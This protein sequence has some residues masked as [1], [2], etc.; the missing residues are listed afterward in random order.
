MKKFLPL[1]L[2]LLI[3]TYK[4]TASTLQNFITKNFEIMNKKPLILLLGATVGVSVL[5]AHFTNENF[6]NQ[7]LAKLIKVNNNDN[8]EIHIKIPKTPRMEN[9]FKI[10][11]SP[12]HEQ[13]IITNIKKINENEYI[14]SIEYNKKKSH[15]VTLNKSQFQASHWKTLIKSGIVGALFILNNKSWL[16]K[17]SNKTK[18]RIFGIIA[19]V[20]MSIFTYS[21]I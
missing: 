3:I 21:I 15:E 1:M 8:I 17:I 18:A 7:I 16:E 4:N 2:F 9:L 10:E 14:F 19:P 13:K 12:P 5:T 11:N 6:K 20:M